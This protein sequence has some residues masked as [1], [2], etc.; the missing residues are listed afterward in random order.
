MGGVNSPKIPYNL[1]EF[2]NVSIPKI[3]YFKPNGVFDIAPC[4]HVQ[5]REQLLR[6]TNQTAQ[7]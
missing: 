7:L 1:R 4:L 3:T 5:L 6:F 2:L